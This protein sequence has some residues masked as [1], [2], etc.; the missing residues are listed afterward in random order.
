MSVYESSRLLERT[1]CYKHSTNT[2][3][4]Y[5]QCELTGGTGKLIQNRKKTYESRTMTFNVE[6]NKHCLLD[7]KMS[8][9]TTKNRT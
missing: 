9:V 8:S 7:I 1:T 6:G 5:L 2:L 3:E 4:S